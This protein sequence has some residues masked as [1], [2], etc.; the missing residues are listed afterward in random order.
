MFSD[1]LL[2]STV[3]KFS[4]TP[5]INTNLYYWRLMKVVDVPSWVNETH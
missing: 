5:L 3:I 2:G 1:E 4:G